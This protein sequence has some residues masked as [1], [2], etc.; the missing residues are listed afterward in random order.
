M[1]D[2]SLDVLVRIL[3]QEVGEEK[4]AEILQK[5]KTAARDLN[6]SLP[7][8]WAG[9][10][11]YKQALKGAAEGGEGA[12]H[13]LHGLRALLRGAGPEAAEFGHLL[14]FAFNPLMLGGAA[15]G[16]GMEAYFHWL[17]KAQERQR[18]MNA[19]LQKHSDWQREIIKSGSVLVEQQRNLS[20]A[21]AESA[22]ALGGLTEQFRAFEQ[23]SKSFDLAQND[24]IAERIGHRKTESTILEDQI[25]MLEQLGKIS[26]PQAEQAKIEAD[27][28]EKLA[29]IQD[30]LT[31]DQSD[32]NS[33]KIDYDQE[34]KMAGGAG[35]FSPEAIAAARKTVEDAQARYNQASTAAGPETKSEIDRLK[36]AI[37]ENKQ[38]DRMY[39]RDYDPATG[40]LRGDDFGAQRT[41]LERQLRETQQSYDAANAGLPEFTTALAT[42]KQHLDEISK[43][44]EKFQSME[45]RLSELATKLR[46]DMHDAPR[47]IREENQRAALEIVN[48]LE[49]N[50]AKPSDIELNAVESINELNHMKEETGFTPQ[51]YAQHGTPAQKAHIANLQDQV[52]AF[53]ALE[54]SLGNNGQAIITHLDTLMRVTGGQQDAL[55]YIYSLGADMERRIQALTDRMNTG[56]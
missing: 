16:A 50:G 41:E 39:G 8:G 51:D 18:E 45:A 2:R 26:K 42:A 35:A 34:L 23:R 5:T 10:E 47:Q 30:R 1:P 11:K 14:H 54:T 28:K 27:H 52:S 44:P 48:A 19:E 17:E 32:Y 12:E 25:T 49:K 31:K 53:S 15:L 36:K 3:T 37:E 6:A 7:E 38:Q 21:I 13:S 29:D 55:E 4:A 43:L 46:D 22:A 56:K 33:A 24:S 20:L 9:F 40:H